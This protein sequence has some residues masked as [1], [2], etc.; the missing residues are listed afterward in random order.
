MRIHTKSTQQHSSDLTGNA[1]GIMCHCFL[2]QPATSGSICSGTQGLYGPLQQPVSVGLLGVISVGFS[3]FDLVP[4]VD[5]L[6]C[7]LSRVCL[8]GAV[9]DRDVHEDVWPGPQEL[10][11][12]LLQ[13]LRLRGESL[14]TLRCRSGLIS[15]SKI[16]SSYISRL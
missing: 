9:P 7:R 11:P 10:L 12:L 4:A 5:R 15:A 16:S 8:L 6:C 14:S 2:K 13:L 3:V 1:M